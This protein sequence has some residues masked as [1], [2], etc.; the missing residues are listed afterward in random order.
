MGRQDRFVWV[1][2]QE[3]AVETPLSLQHTPLTE[4]LPAAFALA[5][6]HARLCTF[7]SLAVNRQFQ[8]PSHSDGGTFSFQVIPCHL[9]LH[10]LHGIPL[11][12]SPGRTD[13]EFCSTFQQAF[14]MCGCHHAFHHSGRQA[15][16]HTSAFSVQSLGWTLPCNTTSPSTKLSTAFSL[17]LFQM[18]SLSC[19]A[20]I[21][22][23]PSF[24]ALP[25]S[26]MLYMQLCLGGLLLPSLALIHHTYEFD[27]VEDCSL[28]LYI[29]GLLP[30]TG[31][32]GVGQTLLLSINMLL[33]SLACLR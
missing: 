5:L 27:Q 24:A 4:Q 8:T 1:L 14:C 31:G 2:V 10:A 20:I 33:S 11:C 26:D 12:C 32:G 29:T 18:P 7:L 3:Q 13:S 28:L 6:L 30:A 16:W 19:L 25:F 21:L 22:A 23:L 17:T 15:A 9:P